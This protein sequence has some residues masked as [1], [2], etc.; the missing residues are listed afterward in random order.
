MLN[1]NS[2]CSKGSCPFGNPHVKAQ[3]HFVAKQLGLWESIPLTISSTIW[4]ARAG[5][6][7]NFPVCFKKQTSAVHVGIYVHASVLVA[8]LHWWAL[9]SRRL[10]HV[11]TTFC[12]RARPLLVSFLDP[13]VEMLRGLKNKKLQSIFLILILGARLQKRKWD[14]FGF[15]TN[16]W[17]F[18]LCP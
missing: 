8:I 12:R 1:T 9:I 6:K 5:H 10:E 7:S 16:Q 11:G 4:W 2:F 14:R 15:I 13:F 3:S 18:K 17:K